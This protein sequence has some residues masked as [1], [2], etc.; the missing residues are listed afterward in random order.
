MKT[1]YPPDMDEAMIPI[2]DAL[3]ALGKIRMQTQFSCEGHGK[4]AFYVLVVVKDLSAIKHL[5]NIFNT[6]WCHYGIEVRDIRCGGISICVESW[7]LGTQQSESIR[8]A[9]F[10]NIVNRAISEC[11]VGV[12]V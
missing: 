5:L 12:I 8:K 1:K 9:E 7:I 6:A 11:D 4:Q 10:D 2:C 3:N